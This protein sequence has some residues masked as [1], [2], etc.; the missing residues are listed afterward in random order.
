MSSSEIFEKTKIDKPVFSDNKLPRTAFTG[1]HILTSIIIIIAVGITFGLT[2]SVLGFDKNPDVDYFDPDSSSYSSFKNSMVA[3]L[4]FCVSSCILMI[5]L[6]VL[7]F[8]YLEEGFTF[9]ERLSNN[10]AVAS[11]GPDR[12]RNVGALLSGMAIRDPSMTKERA[13]YADNLLKELRNTYYTETNTLPSDPQMEK[14]KTA[15]TAGTAGTDQGPIETYV[16]PSDWDLYKQSLSRDTQGIRAG[17]GAFGSNVAAGASFTKQSLRSGFN[18]TNQNVGSL[19]DRFNNWRTER[20]NRQQIY[21]DER[22]QRQQEMDYENFLNK[23]NPTPLRDAGGGENNPFSALNPGSGGDEPRL[24]ADYQ[25]LLQ[26]D[27]RSEE[28]P[29]S[30]PD[31][32]DEVMPR[33]NREMV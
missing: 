26:E 1:I 13:Q 23:D 31:G 20:A 2:W 6:T 21:Q 22:N 27:R 28:V 11:E 32:D 3:S 25:N 4:A 29:Q 30:T 15:Y 19:R 10:L 17:A 5:I 33:F 18:T 14:Y 24:L 7:Y 9:S 8:A 12:L 16:P